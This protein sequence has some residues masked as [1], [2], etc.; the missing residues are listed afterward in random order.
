MRH[1]NLET[2]ERGEH[3][4]YYNQFAYPHFNMCANMEMTALVPPLKKHGIKITV[5]I[6]YIIARSANEIPEFR[7]RI[8]EDEVVEHEVVHPSTTILTDNDMFSFC[9]IDYSKDF[10]VFAHRATEQIA[11]VL[12]NPD[13]KDEAGQDNLLYMTAIPWVSFT[14]FMHPIDFPVDSIPR[15]AWGK[16]FQ[17]GETLKM[18]LNVQAHHGLM[19]GLHMGRFYARVQDYLHHPDLFLD[20]M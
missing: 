11:Y 3:F 2:W 16:F 5:A 17:K 18:P 13:I 12:E 4:K 15:F 20:R 19:D 7:Y 8:R 14:G 9:N 10:S 1:I 6:V